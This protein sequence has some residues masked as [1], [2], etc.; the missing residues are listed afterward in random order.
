MPMEARSQYDYDCHDL[1]IDFSSRQ[2]LLNERPCRLSATEWTLL[3]CLARRA[4]TVVSRDTLKQEVWGF[5][6]GTSTRAVD[7]AIHKLRRKIEE[8][9][10]TPFYLQTIYRKGYRL[11]A[12]AAKASSMRW[13]SLRT[14]TP[15]L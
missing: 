15:S 10:S 11:R 14:A 4:G 3:A 8:D 2:A 7:L 1:K 9:T 6:P 13:S 5:E 12:P